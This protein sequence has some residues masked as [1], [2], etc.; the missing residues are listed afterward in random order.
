MR[1]VQINCTCGIGSTGRI[2]V[3]ISRRLS[4]RGIQ[5]HILYSKLSSGY[6]LGIPCSTDGYLKIQALKSRLLGNFGFNSVRSTRKMIAQLEQIDPD[7][8]HLHNIHGHDCHLELLFSYF[9]EKKTKLIWTFHDCWAFTGYCPHFTMAGCDKWQSSCGDCPQRR[10]YSWLFDR[11][12]DLL[13]RKKRLLNGLDLTIVT[14]SVWLADVVKRSFLKEY[15]VEVIHNGIDL[16]VFRQKKSDFRMRYGIENAKLVLGVSFDWG[17]KKGLDVFIDLAHRLPDDYRIILIGTSEAVEKQLPDN[18]LSIRRTQDQQELAEIYTAADVF[19]NPTREEN[20]PT[21]NMEALACSTPV[22]TFRT[23][24][25]PEMIDET[26]GS[27][28]E[29]DDVDAL[30]KEII[31]VCDN[32]PFSRQACL[33]KAREFDKNNRFEEYVKLYERIIPSGDQRD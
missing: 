28:V 26:C 14:P 23:G 25:S 12:G 32:R 19:V 30:E 21:V 18:I 1:I 7:I 33:E 5:N 10:E 2:C 20:F 17:R 3:D 22:I 4:E 11:S 8:V 6:E 16:S 31:R 29:C 9:K 27:V 24:G 15:P 13:D